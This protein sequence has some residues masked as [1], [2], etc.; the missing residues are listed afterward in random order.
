MR[1]LLADSYAR[2]AR[3]RPVRYK[4]PPPAA[5]VLG[6]R[7]PIRANRLPDYSGVLLAPR[8]GTKRSRRFA[9]GERDNT[10]RLLRGTP[11]RGVRESL[12]ADLREAD[13]AGSGGRS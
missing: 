7:A 3:H 1:I 6:S 4:T 9:G 10:V 2:S 13:D 12:P 11:R 5:S 8:P